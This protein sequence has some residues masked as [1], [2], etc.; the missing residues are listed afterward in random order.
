M[1][2]LIHVLNP[3]KLT[4]IAGYAGRLALMAKFEELFKKIASEVS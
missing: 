4:Q 1:N 2:T 3:T